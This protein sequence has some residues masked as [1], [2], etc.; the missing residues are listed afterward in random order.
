MAGV[1]SAVV[2]V[3]R[4]HHKLHQWY[5]EPFGNLGCYPMRIYTHRLIN[6]ENKYLYFTRKRLQ[7]GW[8]PPE[9]VHPYRA[10]EIRKNPNSFPE[11]I[12]GWVNHYLPIYAKMFH[13][14]RNTD[15]NKLFPSFAHKLICMQYPKY[16][17]V[18]VYNLPYQ[19]IDIPDESL[20][21]CDMREEF[22]R[23]NYVVPDD[24]FWAWCR[25]KA[26]Q[27]HTVLVKSKSAPEDFTQVAAIPITAIYAQGNPKNYKKRDMLNIYTVN[28]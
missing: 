22:M 26:T 14:V 3:I 5:V 21:F 6:Y 17:S 8:I 28:A 2:P 12:V 11:E 10:I 15:P 20:I 7:E 27:K 25:T 19:K 9:F 23:H 4:K 24:E 16:K 13:Q 1:I 18:Q